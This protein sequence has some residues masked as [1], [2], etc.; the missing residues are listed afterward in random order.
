MLDTH[1]PARLALHQQALA[2]ALD[3]YQ[4]VV[5]V[6]GTLAVRGHNLGVPRVLAE[7]EDAGWRVG[8]RGRDGVFGA[9]VDEEEGVGLAHDFV[10]CA[11]LVRDHGLARRVALVLRVRGRDEVVERAGE[12]QLVKDWVVSAE[13]VP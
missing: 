6:R 5:R 10:L 1:V 8:R 13:A 11:L 2:L 9:V 3:V 12:V 4:L 7:Q